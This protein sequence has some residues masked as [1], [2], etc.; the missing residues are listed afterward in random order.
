MI[1]WNLI[2]IALLAMAIGEITRPDWL[3]YAR[4]VSWWTVPRGPVV[5][6]CSTSFPSASISSS[7]EYNPCGTSWKPLPS[8]VC[9]TR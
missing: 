6:S 9:W 8:I 2:S 3:P 1:L 4:G 5:A 7:K